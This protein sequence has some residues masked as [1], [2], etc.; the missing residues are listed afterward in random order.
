MPISQLGDACVS[1]L[2]WHFYFRWGCSYLRC[3]TPD[4]MLHISAGWCRLISRMG[5]THISAV[6]CPYLSRLIPWAELSAVLITA[7]WQSY[8]SRAVVRLDDAGI[9]AQWRPYF[10][11]VVHICHL[12]DTRILDIVCF[13]DRL[14]PCLGWITPILWMEAQREVR[15]HWFIYSY[16]SA[17][18]QALY[19]CCLV[20]LEYIRLVWPPTRDVGRCPQC[21]S[22]VMPLLD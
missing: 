4:L 7:G 18:I 2:M 21:L 6:C 20:L 22:L 10:S 12:D 13:P 9:S 5:Y 16:M 19:M 1:Q 14:R 8:L 11:W 3:V 15:Q 17:Y